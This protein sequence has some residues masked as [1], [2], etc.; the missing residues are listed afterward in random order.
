[1]IAPIHAL[2]LYID[3]RAPSEPLF[4]RWNPD[5]PIALT[6]VIRLAD[7]YLIEGL[8]TALMRHVISDWP[9]TLAAWDASEGEAN[10]IRDT[11]KRSV[12]SNPH[13]VRFADQ[14]PEPA[15]AIVFAREFACPEILPAVFY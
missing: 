12:V 3:P 5:A 11:Y 13:A 8:R 4:K 9:C 2:C 7:K 6:P 1:M 14:I 10:A 15:A